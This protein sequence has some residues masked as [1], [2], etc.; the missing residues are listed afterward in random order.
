MQSWTTGRVYHDWTR[1]YWQSEEYY[2]NKTYYD[3]F[4]A[5]TQ[6]PTSRAT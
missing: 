4:S 1:W 5:E 2:N 6:G 3:T